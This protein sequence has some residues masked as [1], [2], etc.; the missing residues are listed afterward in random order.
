MALY[1]G[2]SCNLIDAV[3]PAAEIVLRH[4]SQRLD[5]AR[6]TDRLP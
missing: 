4:R 6:T 5:R 1:A 3:Q 2:Q